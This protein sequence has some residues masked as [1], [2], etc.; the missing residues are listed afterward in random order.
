MAE[1]IK[2]KPNIIHST[3]VD[4]DEAKSGEQKYN[5]RSLVEGSWILGGIQKHSSR[6][7]LE[8]CPNNKRDAA[9]QIPV[10]Q[11]YVE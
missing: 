2:T 5:R 7:F 11:Q 6:C 8:I 9:T 10:I 1:D 3:V 4:I